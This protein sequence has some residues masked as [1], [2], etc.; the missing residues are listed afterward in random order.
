MTSSSPKFF[1]DSYIMFKRCV[2]KNLRSPEAV[3]MAFIVPVV[4]MVLFGFVFGGIVDL[5]EISYINFIVPGIIV[6]CVTN[7]SATTSF[8]IH[9]DMSTG[10]IDRFRSMAIA[11]SAVMSGHVWVSV[12]RSIVITTV[13]ILTAFAIGF[14]PT[15]GLVEWLQVAALLTLFMIAVTWVVVIF[16]L[17]AKDAESISGTSFLLTI[18]VFLSSAFAP[19]ETL[20][21]ALRIFAENQPMTHV[22]NA[23][24]NLLLG[25]PMDGEFLTA[26][27]WCVGITVVAF[28]VSVQIYKAKLTR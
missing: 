21:T 7:A 22:I 20:P 8:S 26:I 15:A 3:F 19:T 6:Q 25:F 24:R 11:K 12:I 10:I 16:G 17:I 18:L 1:T 2:T 28:T 9:N 13:V 5:G 23:L 27:V 14:R 4:L